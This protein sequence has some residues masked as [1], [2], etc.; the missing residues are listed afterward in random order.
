LRVTTEQLQQH[1]ARGIKPLYTVFGD[2]PLLAL[3]ASDRIRATLRAQGY[4]EREVLTAESGFNW[5]DLANA[6]SSQSL[7][8]S[9]KLLELRIPNGK[10]GTEGGAALQSFSARLPQDTVTLVQLPAL[11]WRAQ[12]S[13]WFESLEDKGVCVEAR[14]VTRKALPQWLA[15]RLKAQ[16]QDADPETLEFIA[17]RVEGNLMAAY[18][19]VQKLALLFP[20]GPITFGQARDAVVD[21]ARYDVFNLGEAMLEGDALRLSRMLDGLKGEGAAAP[22]ALWSLTEEIRAIGKIQSGVAAGKP[23]SMVVRDA[24]VRGAAHQNLMQ[25]NYPRFTPAQVTDALRHAAHVDR[26]IKGLVKGDLWDELLQ[27][28]LRFTRSRASA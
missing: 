5:S 18:Q 10:P 20:P 11:D 1:L 25:A 4:S 17:D 15:G 3:E 12:K 8:A 2:E 21:V 19:E 9:L 27:L 24:R 28:A 6:A 16:K 22:L 13:A 7:F 23:V 26:M 14:V